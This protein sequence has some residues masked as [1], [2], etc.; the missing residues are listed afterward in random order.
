[1]NTS[2]RITTRLAAAVVGLACCLMAGCQR[3]D[4]APAADA[5]P[6]SF[7]GTRFERKPNAA[8]LTELGRALFA[9]A[10]LSASGRL[11]CSSCHDPAHAYGPPNGLAVQRGGGDLAQPGLRAV[12]SLRYAQDTHPFDEHYTETEGDDSI[13]QGPA[14]GWTWDGR[15]NSAHAQAALPLLSPFEMGNADEAA[16]VARLRASSSAGPMRAA[17]GAHVLDDEHLAWNGLLLALE[18]FQQNPADFYPYSSR[19]DEYL[20]GRASLSASE[21]HGLQLFND[22]QRGNCAECHV[23]AIKRGAF[24]SFTDRGLIALA[25]PRNGEI[26]ANADPHY[27]DLGLCGPL[28]TDLVDHPEYC[29]L[30]KTPTLRNVATRQVF[31]H[32]GRFHTLVEA[33]RFYAD[34][35][36]HPARYYGKGGQADDLPERYRDNINREEPFAAQHPGKPSLSEPEIADIV[37][38]LRTLTDGDA[39]PVPNPQAVSGERHAANTSI[40]PNP[41]RRAR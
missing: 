35:D 29:G 40:P 5:P 16:V 21:Q 18:V 11:S 39:R 41:G 7:Y 38:F 27:F 15:A 3:D 6:Q 25:V 24:P 2:P 20:R 26:A 30:F 8:E 1:M 22:P 9:D 12:P 28:R 33:V 14:G 10:A 4:P 36:A 17:F 23:S 19:Y 34:R 31:F 32:N 37:A 13:D